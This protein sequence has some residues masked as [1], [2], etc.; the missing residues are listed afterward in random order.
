MRS[1]QTAAAARTFR[2]GPYLNS[3]FRSAERMDEQLQAEICGRI[4]EARIEAG[5]TQEEAADVLSI[6]QRA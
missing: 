2:S 5:F 4:R 6:T 3:L 1:S